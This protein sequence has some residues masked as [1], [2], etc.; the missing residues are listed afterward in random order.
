MLKILVKIKCLDLLNILMD[1][2]NTIY[3]VRYWSELLFCTIMNTLGDLKVKVTD[4]KFYVRTI[5][6][7]SL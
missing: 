4:L 3:V 5:I 6:T 7:I 1:H 2:V